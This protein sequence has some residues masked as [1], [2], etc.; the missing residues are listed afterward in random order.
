MINLI[1]RWLEPADMETD[2]IKTRA[3]LLYAVNMSFALFL[4]VTLIGKFLGGRAQI[5]RAHV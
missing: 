3:K 2:T 4:I 1:K 5:G